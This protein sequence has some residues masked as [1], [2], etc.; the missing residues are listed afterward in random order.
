MDRVLQILKERKIFSCYIESTKAGYEFG[1][2]YFAFHL[3]GKVVF[4]GG[5]VDRALDLANLAKD[6]P[7]YSFLYF[8][9]SLILVIYL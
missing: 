1:C 9:I 7:Q 4:N 3:E 8:S 5:R 6:L 2:S